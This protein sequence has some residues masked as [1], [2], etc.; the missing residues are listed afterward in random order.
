MGCLCGIA[1]D[2]EK[3]EIVGGGEWDTHQ[4]RQEFGM[5]SPR[6]CSKG[7][8]FCRGFPLLG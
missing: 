8:L 6:V 5:I 2:K 7:L 3:W 1:S 4:G